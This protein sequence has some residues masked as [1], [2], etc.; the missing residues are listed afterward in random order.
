LALTG[1]AP[2]SHLEHRRDALNYPE[3]AERSDHVGGRQLECT[4]RVLVDSGRDLPTIFITALGSEAAAKALASLQ[5]V[6]LLCKPFNKIEL[7]D[8]IAQV[9]G[10]T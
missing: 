2:S 9:S 5:P 6:T 10:V 3:R 4:R 7:L 1:C 8:A